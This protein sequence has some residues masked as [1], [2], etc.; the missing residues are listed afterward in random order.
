MAEM[1]D[2]DGDKQQAYQ[3]HFDVS[4]SENSKLAFL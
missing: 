1:Y 3:Y 4:T 2:N